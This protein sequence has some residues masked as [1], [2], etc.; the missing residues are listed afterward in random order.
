MKRTTIAMLALTVALAATGCGEAQEEQTSNAE[1]NQEENT[2]AENSQLETEAEQTEQDKPETTDTPEQDQLA[3][4]A[5]TDDQ[6]LE[7]IKNYV[8]ETNPDVQDMENSDDYTLY[9]EVVSS[10]ENEIVVLYRSYTAAQVRYYIDPV[11]GDTRVTEF[12]PGITEEEEETGET[13]NVRDYM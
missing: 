3:T 13:F 9:F 4:E 6:A 11:S 10:D 7:A 5:L 1:I 12:V 8:Y 2:Q